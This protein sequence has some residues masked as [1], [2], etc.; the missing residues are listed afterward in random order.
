MKNAEYIKYIDN[1]IIIKFNNI[2]KINKIVVL[3]ILLIYIG[4]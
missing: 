4:G 2:N 3:L 1:N